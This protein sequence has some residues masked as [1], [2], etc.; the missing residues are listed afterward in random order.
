[1][2][3][4]IAGTA[5]GLFVSPEIAPGIKLLHLGGKDRTFGNH[6]S[7]NGNIHLAW[8]STPRNRNP[9]QSGWVVGLG[10]S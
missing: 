5:I 7:K 1:M 4:L 2:K 3:A 6:T 8:T 9:F 10:Y